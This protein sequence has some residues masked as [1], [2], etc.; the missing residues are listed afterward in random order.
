MVEFTYTKGH[1]ILDNGVDLDADV[2]AGE[3]VI[4][5]RSITD[6][7]SDGSLGPTGYKF[8]QYNLDGTP[9]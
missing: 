6:P 1:R 8:G 9:L 5:K 4:M 3:P 7:V 2:I